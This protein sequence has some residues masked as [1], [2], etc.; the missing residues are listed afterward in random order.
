M[1]AGDRV[2]CWQF[3]AYPESV[4]DGWIDILKE[5]HT[6]FCVSPL[7]DQDKMPD[8]TL[9]KAHWHV[10]FI[11]DGPHSYDQMKAITDSVNA[12]PPQRIASIRGAVRYLI[13]LD[14]PE[15]HPYHKEEVR[16][17]C[18]CDVSSYFDWSQSDQDLAIREIQHY[19]NEYN[20][21]EFCDLLNYAYETEPCWYYVLTHTSTNLFKTF[22]AS[23]RH[24]HEVAKKEGKQVLCDEDG[25]VLC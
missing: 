6:Q 19:C 10:I 24:K 2:R 11:F 7:H 21:I 25:E 14:D 3:I 13:H 17:F 20:I 5:H 16:F 4:P 9:K 18:G 15:K 23:K 8:G 22:L 12:A 1:S